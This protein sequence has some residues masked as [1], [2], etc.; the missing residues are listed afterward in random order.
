MA[1]QPTRSS[2]TTNADGV[3][4]IGRARMRAL[5]TSGP[6][7]EHIDAVRFLSNR[8]SGRMGTA[9]AE[10]LAAR[11]VEVRLGLGPV[12]FEP[13]IT[14]AQVNPLGGSIEVLRF[15]SAREL[16]A[17]M[18]AE[19]PHAEMVIMAAAVADF[20]PRS[21]VA[22]KLPRTSAT[23]TLELEP[24]PDL[25]QETR[26]CRK[27]GARIV[28]FALEPHGQ[29]ESSA[30]AKMARKDLFAIVANPL[31]TMDS[32]DV[33]AMLMMRDGSTRTMGTRVSK[34]AFAT[35]LVDQLL[36]DHALIDSP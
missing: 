1:Q 27:P 15:E 3:R 35:W 21:C 34:V 17:L 12:R 33:D 19:L 36:T 18:R 8:S 11:G 31:E 14:G 4:L 22:G 6:T 7:H 20:R 24:V 32:P 28:G 25:L 30:A 29:L 5:V 9:I 2:T 10:A 23:L 16:E 13:S 26:D